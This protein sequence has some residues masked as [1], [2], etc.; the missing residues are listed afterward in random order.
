VSPSSAPSDLREQLQEALGS[1]YRI[2]R[3]LGGG[4]M[5]RVFLTRDLS[6]DRPV[7]VKVLP[8]DLTGV[9]VE[10]F[11]REISVAARLQHPHIVPLLAAGEMRGLPYYTMPFVVG[12]SLRHH[13][14]ASGPLPVGE[15]TRLLRD[16]A[17]ALAHA[18]REG[19]VH[20]DIKPDNIMLAGGTATV[21]DFG[22][23]KAVRDAAGGGAAGHSGLT[24]LGIALGTPAYMAPEQAAADPNVD[25]R[26]DLYAFGVLAY[27]MLAGR[28]PFGH[29]PAQ[30]LLVAHLT[31]VPVP[32]AEVREDVPEA[33]HDLVMG[34]LRKKPAERPRSA[35]ALV[36][37]LDA[38]GSGAAA[39]V[40]TPRWLTPSGT[41][42]PGAGRRAIG[43]YV[44]G[45]VVSAVL[46]KVAERVVGLPDWVFH[47]A[48][49][50]LAA[51][52]LLVLA[53]AV[54]SS[55][56]RRAGVPSRP[57]ATA[58]LT[59]RRAAYAC[60]TAL[61]LYSLLVSGWM[62][63]RAIG[64]GP[65]ATL[66][67]AG[68]IKDRARIVVTDFR[69]A[70]NDSLL[71][72]VVT[73]AL[74]TDLSQSKVVS[75]VQTTTVQQAL[76]RMQRPTEQKLDLA[77]AR[78]VALREGAAAV[79]DGDVTPIGTGVLLVAR[80][81]SAEDGSVL[82][83]FRA[84]ASDADGVIPAINTLS[85]DIRGKIGESL[86][87]IRA[88]P[89][90]DEV[91][92]ASLPALRKYAEGVR[93]IEVAGDMRRGMTLLEEAVTLDS[94][95][96][97]AYR[98]LGV[99]LGNLGTEPAKARRMLERAYAFRD[100][101]PPV[102][103]GLAEASWYMSAEGEGVKAQAALD[104]VLAIDPDNRTALINSSV[105][106][107]ERREFPRAESL[108]VRAV[109]SDS[110]RSQPYAN[111]LLAQFAMGRTADARRTI[112][113][114][115][116]RF[117]ENRQME[118]TAASLDAAVGRYDSAAARFT[119]LARR[120]P[121]EAGGTDDAASG[122]FGLAAIALVEGRLRAASPHFVAGNRLRAAAGTPVSPLRQPVLEAFFDAFFRGQPGQARRRIDAVAT[123]AA[124]AKL[125]VDQR[126]YFDLAAVHALAGRPEQARMLVAEADT[127][128]RD[129][130]DAAWRSE[131]ESA[132][133]EI[134]L[135]EGKPRDAIRA[136]QRA[137][138]GACRICI[139]PR[140]GAAYDLA[141]DRDSAIAVFERY[142]TT[143]DLYRLSTDA[144]YLAGI[145]KR[146]G[147][148][149]EARGD[150]ARALAAYEQF[151]TLWRAAD[152][153]LQ[154]AVQQVRQRIQMLRTQV[155][156]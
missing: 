52:L 152:P 149:Y 134:L 38:L 69:A 7:V 108:L 33:L 89:P 93:M 25:H 53:T 3:E 100:K 131:R 80:L 72:S 97:M 64:V 56:R 88:E 18:H 15:A 111:L 12:E 24:S 91:T 114:V 151:V 39:T 126:L 41:D 129:L 13:L 103:R 48:L 54:A 78:D 62:V 51:G 74:R 36:A 139:L 156:A 22:V 94:T 106:A 59:W 43:T 79:L 20:R 50:L 66:L 90:L 1:G 40:R 9:S 98:K 82:A 143:P 122:E 105:L 135:A 128:A 57:G 11:K 73:E 30:E 141:G 153:E 102:E 109:R 137:D 112:E 49:M 45:A 77:S 17:S 14:A 83:A 101:L 37:A 8:P 123:R 34:C 87:D 29:R 47:G 46:A 99:T 10:R 92:T 124:L 95:F 127:A 44:V 32:L 68:V 19:V 42:A 145:Q 144:N 132:L 84:S 75:L 155:K 28:T 31:E 146:L 118:V 65:G 150:K 120:G 23:A 2:E 136:F 85:R 35:D 107:L 71:G 5:S 140:L 27:E 67:A 76:R 117:P 115:R 147:E 154:P 119:A 6:L 113:A 148:L 116:R 96:A 110:S 58:T 55:R 133:G 26:A 70:G 125:P 142:R 81:V 61:G 4:G 60:G 63:L 138:S 130:Q 121:G 16:V 104:G 21:L 86:R